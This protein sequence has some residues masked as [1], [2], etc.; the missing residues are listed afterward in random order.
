M[1]NS[2]FFRVYTENDIYKNTINNNNYNNICTDRNSTMSPT[3]DN[4]Q[5]IVA[6]HQTAY[7]NA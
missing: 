4:P 2:K 7:T 6:I 1:R 5:N 3:D